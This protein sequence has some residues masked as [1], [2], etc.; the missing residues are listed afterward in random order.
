MPQAAVP[1]QTRKEPY[2]I[3]LKLLN[4]GMTHPHYNHTRTLQSRKCSLWQK[5]KKRK[6]TDIIWIRTK[7]PEGTT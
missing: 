6:A 7:A 4:V 5:R 3:L 2:Q 1:D